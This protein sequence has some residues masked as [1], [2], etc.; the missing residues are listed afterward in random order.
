MALAPTG[1]R[2]TDRPPSPTPSRGFLSST[3]GK[4][5]VMAVSG[6]IM[7]GYLVAH[8]AGNLKVFFGPEE[9][10]EYAHWLRVMGAPLLH[11]E[12]ALWIVR[13]VLLAAVGAHA[14]SAYQLSRRD[15]KARPTAYVHRRRR[16]SYATRTMR[17]GG[18][19]LALFIVWHI[20]DL[21][22]GTVH[23]GGFEEGKPYQNVV[24]TFS[25]WYGNVIY[26][27]A[28]LAVGLHVRHGFWSAAQTLGVG[29]ARRERLLR[30]L[31]NGLAVALTAGFVS[32][33]VAV[34]TGVVS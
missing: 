25:T 30:G 33:P 18:I 1:N 26:I 7:L 20:L 8:V 29:N 6:L 28:M 27:V 5:T 24:D 11:H 17:W 3:L 23:T 31:A 4:K 16:A 22:T 15:I 14:V 34:M 10:N 12:W 13:I 32:V 9:F 19:I 21:T 2:T